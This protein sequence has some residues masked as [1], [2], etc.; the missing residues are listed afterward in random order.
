[1]EWYEPPKIRLHRYGI[2]LASVV[3]AGTFLVIRLGYVFNHL[4][5]WVFFALSIAAVVFL[6]LSRIG[7]RKD[8]P[9]CI[10]C[11]YSLRGLGERGNC[12]EC[13]LAFEVAECAAYALDPRGYRAHWE[14]RQWL[15]SRKE[16]Q[17]RAPE[18]DRGA[19][20]KDL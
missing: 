5:L 3:A 6:H 18:N 17:R 8:T 4:W 13:S 11:G 15:A 1:M 9:F 16:S 2:G 14:R 10:H 20:R 19:I 7:I 12:P